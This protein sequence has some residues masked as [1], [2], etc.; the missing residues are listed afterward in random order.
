MYIGKKV[1]SPPPPP[2]AFS[3]M[4]EISMGGIK[5]F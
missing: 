5:N 1:I 3:L 4:G 2:L